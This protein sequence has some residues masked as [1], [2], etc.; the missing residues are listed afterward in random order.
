MNEILDE[1][2]TSS[3]SD[4]RGKLI[5]SPRQ[6]EELNYALADYLQSRGYTETLEVFRRETDIKDSGNAKYNGSVSYTHL[7]LPTK[8]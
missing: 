3:M 6:R 4:L 1:E 7:T 2:N 5:L 8:A